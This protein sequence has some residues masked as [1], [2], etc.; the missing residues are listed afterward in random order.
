VNTKNPLLFTVIG[1]V[2][3][4]F[5]FFNFG[6]KPKRQEASDAKQK[7]AEAQ[8]KLDAA[9]ALLAS[10]QAARES[11]RA[12]Y[13]TVVRL[14]K[15]VPGD[16]DVR[17]LVVQL[18]RAAKATRVDFQSIEVGGTNGAAV[19]PTTPGASAGATLPPGAT[20]GPAGFPVMPFSFSFR[21]GFFRLAKFFQRLDA[22]VDANNKKVSVSGRLLTVDGL[23][24]EQDESGFPNIKAT[25]QATSYLVNPLEGATGGATPAGPATS[26]GAPAAPSSADDGGP[27]TTTATST[28]GIR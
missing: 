7:V 6:L 17:S 9:R 10:N 3:A 19:T 4:G 5:L 2:I 15:A 21:G 27:V 28:G 13:A 12:D 8:D 26:T 11:Y 1:F 22:F 14:G 24:L 16:D 18:D 23:K 25:V 20:V